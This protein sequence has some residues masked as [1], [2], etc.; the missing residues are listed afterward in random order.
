[1]DIRPRQ[2]ETWYMEVI[3]HFFFTVAVA[4]VRAY[5]ML[6]SSL[7]SVCALIYLIL[8]IAGERGTIMSPFYGETQK[9]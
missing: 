8:I 3:W 7:S 4:N 6:A 9:V 5:N 1:M 2:L